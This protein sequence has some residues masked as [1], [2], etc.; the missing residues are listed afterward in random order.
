[1]LIADILRMSE[2]MYFEH[3]GALRAAYPEL[4]SRTG[5]LAAIANATLPMFLDD[6][7]LGVIVLDFTE[8]HHFT[9]AERRF[10]TILAGQ[11]AVALGRAEVRRTLEH[12][13]RGP[14]RQLEEE[15]AAQAAFV[16]FTEAV[17]SETDLPT[18]I[19]QAITVLQGRFPGAS[20]ST[21]RR[22]ETSGEARV[23]SDDLRPELVA[24]IT[25]GLPVET[26]LFAQVSPDPAAGVH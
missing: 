3:A 15:Q 20:S 17:G 7:P 16:T 1:M 13:S 2:A 24:L 9:Q 23:W 11:C 25:A 26:P 19:R 4:E 10:L 14:T 21:T 22:R 12:T 18:L 8:P 5:G 6:Q